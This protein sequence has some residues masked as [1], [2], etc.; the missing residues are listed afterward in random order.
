MTATES[1][2]V[3]ARSRAFPWTPLAVLG[4]AVFLSVTGEMLPAGLLPEMSADLR[5]A[6]PA[7]GL[8]VTVFA[9]TVVATSA[10]LTALTQWMPRRRLLVIALSVLAVA[11]LLTAV[12]PDYAWIVG[13]RVVGGLAHGVFWALVAAYAARLVPRELVGR[14]VAVV[15]GGGTLAL[16]LGVPLATT[17]GQAAGWRTAFLLLGVLTAVGALLV[18]AVLPFAQGTA[19]KAHD[20]ADAPAARPVLRDATVPAV[21]AV[22][23]VT[24]LTMTGQYALY[25]YVAPL[26]TDVVGVRSGTVGPLLFVYGIAGAVGLVL[27]GSVLGRRP[28]AG[29]VVAMSAA[30]AAVVGIV[31]AQ[32]ST[33]LALAA[34]ALWGVAFGAVPPLLQT[35][36]LQSASPRIRDVASALYT[37]AFNVGIGGGAMVGALLYGGF[38]VVALPFAFAIVL[39]A[40]VGAV[41]APVLRARRRAGVA[42]P[43]ATS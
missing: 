36:L 14:A 24:A 40:A 28:T 4:A 34:F 29:L 17:L 35:R 38:G 32:G 42:G 16:V 9:F 10:P 31:L 23:V 12:S 11:Q 13:S 25:T 37:T 41:L 39:L 3:R 5:V 22:C 15:L 43:A 21:V 27:A 7:I 6:E 1:V 19:E 18:R 8:L 30:A 20:E 2:S 26:L 33:V